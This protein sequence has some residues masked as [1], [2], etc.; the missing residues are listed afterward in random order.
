MITGAGTALWVR[1]VRF[2]FGVLGIVA[3]LWIPLRNL[4][5]D[6]FSLG[7]YLSYFTIES[8]IFGVFVL[9]TGGLLDPTGRRWQTLR[10]AATLYLLITGVVYAVLLANIDVMLQ[11]RWINDVLHRVL[12]IVLVADWLLVPARLGISMRLVASWLIYP[13]VYGVY[14]LI[15][16]AMVHW[17]PYPFLDPRTQGYASLFIG[18]VVLAVVFAFLAAAIAG[19]GTLRSAHPASE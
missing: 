14:S 13:A 5:V 12:P 2:G 9:V 4:G 1:A 15:R 19:L 6:G 8:N 7:N 10:G 17:Y 16:G 18:L 11:D 3:L